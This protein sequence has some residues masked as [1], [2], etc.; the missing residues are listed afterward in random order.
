MNERQSAYKVLLKIQKNNSYSNLALDAELSS[1]D[2]SDGKA[3]VSALVY[4]TLERQITLDYVLSL[5]LKQPIQKLKNEVLVALRLGAYQILF[6]D[7]IPSFAA[8]NES[9][10]IV[11][12]S[13]FSFASGLVNSVLR[14]VA[15]N[16]IT[17][18][19]TEDVIFDLS[20]KYSC[21]KALT[22]HYFND[23]GMDNTVGILS[24]SLGAAPVTARVN[25]VKVSA[26]KLITLLKNEG[27]N[28]Q[29]ISETALNL[30]DCGCFESLSAYREGLFHIEDLASQKCCEILGAKENETVIDVC[31]APGGKTFTIAEMMNNKGRVLSF[32]LYEKRVGLINKGADR[33]GLSIV[34]AG[35]SDATL[36][37]EKMPIADRVLC[38]VPCSGLGIIRRKPEIKFKNLNEFDFLTQMQYNILIVSSK[39]LKSGGTLVYS[40]CTLNKKENEENC[41][42]FL[43]EHKEFS[44]DMDYLTLF[45][46]INNS[47][48][49]FTARFIRE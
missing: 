34:S 37:N 47:D 16:G 3:L 18:P 9:V 7:K 25:T 31:A 29:K 44:L 28:A 41:N 43:E 13:H 10:K 4:G 12:N 24:T 5:Y 20:I 48:G 1:F 42:R 49:F 8:V 23:Y 32:D 22:E 40:T 11:K 6:M 39:Y 36:F 27:V 45:P 26:D 30:L 33:L 46:H 38:D 19:E 35:V 15:Q 14:K 17:Y 21:P 2:S